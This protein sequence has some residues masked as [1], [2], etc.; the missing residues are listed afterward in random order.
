MEI[1]R[2]TH[3]DQR[4]EE[5]HSCKENVRCPALSNMDYQAGYVRLT[6]MQKAHWRRDPDG[7]AA[8]EMK[9]ILEEF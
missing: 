6:R 5:E 3:P 4:G 8:L 9:Y 1:P 7:A 2:K